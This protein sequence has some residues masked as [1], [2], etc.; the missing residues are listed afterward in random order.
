MAQSGTGRIRE[1]EDQPGGG[2]MTLRVIATIRTEFAE[3]F[4][5][6]RQSGLVEGLRGEIVFEAAYR[7]AEALKGIDEFSHLWLLWG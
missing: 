2:D 1:K 6:P 7:N 3:K 5:V 4:G